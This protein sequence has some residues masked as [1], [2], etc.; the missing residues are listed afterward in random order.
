MLKESC[1]IK[2]SQMY[3]RTFENYFKAINNQYH[4]FSPYE[5]VI[6]FN[7]RY[8]NDEF[9]IMFEELSAGIT[10]QEVSKSIIQLKCGRSGG[11]DQL[12]NEFFICGERVLI[13]VL[14]T[15]LISDLE[16]DIFL[17]HGLMAIL[18]LHIKREV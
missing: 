13:P 14:L 11:P 6:Y 10:Q 9:E 17:K 7:E 15:I 2:T 1:G 8:L 18:S 12:L 5:D 4:F 3:I 16:L